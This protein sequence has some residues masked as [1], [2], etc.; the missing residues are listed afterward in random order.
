MY[1]IRISGP[2]QTDDVE[3]FG[4]IGTLEGSNYELTQAVAFALGQ[5]WK[6]SSL[7]VEFEDEHHVVKWATYDLEGF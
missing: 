4:E 7:Q 2:I 1:T 5:N 3:S 6:D